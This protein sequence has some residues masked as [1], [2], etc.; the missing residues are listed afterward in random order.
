M[1]EKQKQKSMQ[2]KP[3]PK[4]QAK[5]MPSKPMVQ[6]SA[7]FKYIVRILNTDLNGKKKV[8][9]ALKSVKGVGFALANAACVMANIDPT[10]RI[11]DISDEEISKLNTIVAEPLRYGMPEWMANRRNDPETGEVKHLLTTD[12]DF[13][14]DNDI[15]LMKKMKS[16][17]GMRHSFGVPVRGQRTR[18]NFRKNKGKVKGVI[19]SRP[20][21]A[22][23]PKKQ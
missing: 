14:K 13:V 15:K 9:H 18:S 4:P 16:Y 7:N 17:K 21:P 3:L 1:D 12:L 10:R 2:Q 22:A 20:T 23:S 11:G 19:K 8:Q 6:E 5:P